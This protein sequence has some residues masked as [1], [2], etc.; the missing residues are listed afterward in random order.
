MRPGRFLS[1]T[2][3][4][5]ISI[6][7][8]GTAAAQTPFVGSWKLNQD[9]SQ[10]AGD[11]MKF[12]PAQGDAIESEGWWGDL[13]LS[14]GRQELRHALG[15]Y[16]HLETGQLRTTWSTEYQ[17]GRRQA[18]S[19]SDIVEAFHGRPE[20]LGDHQ[21]RQSRWRSVYQHGR[22][23]AHRGVEWVDGGLEEHRSQAQL[24]G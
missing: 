19:A 4:L 12:G 2:I 24:T 23:C 6:V 3:W 22:V 8:I 7:T 20:A 9:K 1:A 13:L 17:K 21:R 18:C 11:T 16:R 5:F 15:Q 14:R 10:L